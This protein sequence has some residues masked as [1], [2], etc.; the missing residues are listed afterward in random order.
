MNHFYHNIN[1]NELLLIAHD[2]DKQ[3]DEWIDSIK[4][5]RDYC[6]KRE[7]IHLCSN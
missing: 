3:G 7:M 5:D 2:L 6:I 4:R 1:E